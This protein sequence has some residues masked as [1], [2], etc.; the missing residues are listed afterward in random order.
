MYFKVESSLKPKCPHD[1]SSAQATRIAIPNYEP[2]L[3][4][5]VVKDKDGHKFDNITSLKIDWLAQPGYLEFGQSTHAETEPIHSSLGYIGTGKGLQT[6]HPNKVSA[7]VEVIAKVKGYRSE[8]LAYHQIPSRKLIASTDDEWYDLEHSLDLRLVA[9]VSVSP[10]TP[11]SL[12]NHPSSK[13]R[14]VFKC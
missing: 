11:V 6:L 7:D 10:S 8:V 3:V 1:A 5:V 9:D 12:F 14:P 2:S 13:V 4:S